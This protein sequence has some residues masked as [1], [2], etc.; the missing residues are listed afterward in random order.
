MKTASIELEDDMIPERIKKVNIHFRRPRKARETVRFAWPFASRQGAPRQRVRAGKARFRSTAGFSRSLTPFIRRFIS[1]L[2]LIT[3]L[4]ACSCSLPNEDEKWTVMSWNVQ[5]LFDGIDDGTEYSEF[6]PGSGNWDDRLYQRRLERTGEVISGGTSGSVDL[7]IL[8]E[9]E[10]PGILDDLADGPLRG[11]AY[12]WRLAI[13]GYSII[14]CGVLSRY[15]LRDID[16]VDCGYYGIRPLRPALAFTV[17]TPA[18][19]VR[20]IALHWKSPRDGRPATEDARCCEAAVSKGLVEPMLLR[21]PDVE[22]LIIGDLNTPGD[23]LVRPAAL[24]PWFPEI[25]PE[26]DEAVLYRTDL[27]EGAGIHDGVVVFFDPDPDPASGPTGTY[28]YRDDWERPDRALLSRGLIESPGLVFE[29]CRT[30]AELVGDGTG[31]PIR[32]VTDWEE[33]YSDHLPL[34]LEFRKSCSDSD[35][36]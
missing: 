6:D 35:D 8:Q 4:T 17:D 23:G 36:G 29:S 31:R 32:W 19:P 3:L 7:V 15:P 21:N 22:I 18:G 10:N 33:G 1:V 30:A 9:L 14:R 5:N 20:V 2:F 12:H 26:T 34:M 27:Q 11:S 28:W 24:A 13:S 16:V 25:D